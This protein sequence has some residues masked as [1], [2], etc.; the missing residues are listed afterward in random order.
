MIGRP[1]EPDGDLL[2]L[3][4]L[5]DSSDPAVG[6]LAR[7]LRNRSGW[8]GTPLQELMPG[9]DLAD[10]S[11][12]GNGLSPRASNCLRRARVTS[13]TELAAMKPCQISA[14]YNAGAMTVE[15][16]L[17]SA[18]SA[19][20]SARL[21]SDEEGPPPTVVAQPEISPGA[22]DRAAV[23]EL[24][25][26]TPDPEADRRLLLALSE[27]G[28]P[29]P[30]HLAR[31]LR[32]RPDWRER[33][34]GT[35]LPGLGSVESSLSSYPQSVR[36]ANCLGR[37]GVDAFTTLEGMAPAAIEAFS[38][39]GPR[40]VE[41]ILVAA[42][43]H[44]ALICLGPVADPA[45]QDDSPP[46][47]SRSIV[48]ESEALRSALITICAWA[49]EVRGTSD[50]LEAVAAAARA[51]GHLPNPVE[52]AVRQLAQLGGPLSEPRRRGLIRAF[53]EIEQM[54]GFEVFKRR[55]LTAGEPPT[56]A[57][58]AEELGV[59]R[60]RI[61][62]LA[63]GMDSALAKRM[64][65]SEWPLRI[66][67]EEMRSR[68]GAVARPDEL[69]GVLAAIDPGGLA[70]PG[71][72]PQRSALLLWLADYQ[73]SGEWILGPDI[74]ALTDV[75]LTAVSEGGSAN[76]DRVGRQ[77]LWLGV[78][79]ELQLQWIMSRRGLVAAG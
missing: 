14:I 76:L 12:F 45:T 29:Q 9:V 3:L 38:G 75:V 49:T 59:T 15:E 4:A 48:S 44:W 77:L 65:N 33:Q 79:E 21:S 71:D 7:R 40:T 13:W 54:R 22:V 5:Q 66:A 72:R 41:E 27:P 70:L 52:R 55:Q 16:I 46:R 23:E 35:L 68:L 69:P 32:E 60:T 28:D 11:S 63:E 10:P 39:V 43:R 18:L 64:R 47:C 58:I 31:L 53:E 67:A 20:A 78:R 42:I 24:V 73:V 30:W 50:A 25:G 51:K 34:L 2:N 62:R 6:K 17:L 8:L 57:A 26:R 1:L 56:P 19:W 37:M 61:Y 74:V 36:A